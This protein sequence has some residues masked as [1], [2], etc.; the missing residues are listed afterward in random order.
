MQ[1]PIKWFMNKFSVDTDIINNPPLLRKTVSENQNQQ[2][3]S[4]TS[5]SPRKISN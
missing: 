1:S 4:H 3:S 2:S 5:R